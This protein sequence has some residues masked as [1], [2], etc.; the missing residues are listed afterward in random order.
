MYDSYIEDVDY[1]NNNPDNLNYGFNII[2]GDKN[3][4]DEKLNK[5]YEISFNEQKMMD[6]WKNS[7]NNR[8][9]EISQSLINIRIKKKRKLSDQNQNNIINTNINRNN[10]N[11]MNKNL[12]NYESNNYSKISQMQL[13]ESKRI[14]YN[15]LIN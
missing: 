8:I 12:I 13:E 15:I 9:E 7:I 6:E 2:F 1:N 3:S 11:D 14:R 4:N 5:K 10:N